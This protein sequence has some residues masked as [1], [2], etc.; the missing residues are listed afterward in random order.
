MTEKTEAE[1]AAEATRRA[2]LRIQKTKRR[3][4]V[5]RIIGETG[6]RDSMLFDHELDDTEPIIFDK[7]SKKWQ[8]HRWLER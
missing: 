4:V 3:K 5:P 2:I 7:R 6:H 8:E 1:R